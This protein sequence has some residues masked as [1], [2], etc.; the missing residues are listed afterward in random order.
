M[1]K[2]IKNNNG[3]LT[4]DQFLNTLLPGLREF[5]IN[6]WGSDKKNKYHHPEDL[7][8]SCRNYLE[9]AQYLISDFGLDKNKIKK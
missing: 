2:N 6:N 8:A 1:S 3:Y 9:A 5:L 7:I 4:I